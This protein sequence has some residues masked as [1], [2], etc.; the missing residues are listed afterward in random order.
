MEKL[1]FRAL[2]FRFD[3]ETHQSIATLKFDNNLEIHV[4]RFVKAD[5][6]LYG[7]YITKDGALY[8]N[9][10]VMR[11]PYGHY[12]SEGVT[13]IMG[14]IQDIPPDK[15][16]DKKSLLIWRDKLKELIDELNTLL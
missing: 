3:K 4:I 1:T 7:V 2:G 12:S 10:D 8:L 14:R 13:N 5:A 6:T 11:E 16:L 9:D 15:I